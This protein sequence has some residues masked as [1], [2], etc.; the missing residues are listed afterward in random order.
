MAKLQRYEEFIERVN[1]LGFMAF[2]NALPGFPSLTQETPGGIWHTG[3]PETDPWRWK[4]RAAEEKKLAFGCVLGGNKGFIAPRMYA[5]FYTACQ[6]EEHIEELHAFGLISPEVWRLWQL[7][8]TRSLLST[9]EIRQEMGVTKRKGGSKADKAVSE[10]EQMFYIT[11]AGNRRK[12]DK[13]G[14]P[15]GWA[16]NVY[17]L[18]EAWAPKEWLEPDRS[19]G[20]EEAKH[21][22]LEQGLAISENVSREQLAKMLKL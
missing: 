11:V 2:S 20:R 7:F 16:A 19:Y 13:F 22:I 8:E 9:S 10:L 18:V 12:T 4:D 6:P 5:L 17:E 15:Y 14:Q 1:E 21:A 3:N